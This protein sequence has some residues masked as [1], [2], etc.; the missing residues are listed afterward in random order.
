MKLVNILIALTL[1]AGFAAASD[2]DEP[3][4]R[5][6]HLG[7]GPLS[8]EVFEAAVAHVDLERCPAEFAD[9]EVF[10]RMTLANGQAHVFV[11]SMDPDTP[12]LAIKSLE[13]TE[14]LLAF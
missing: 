6:M 3:T 7:D 9:E 8:Y 1:P 13:L 14:D 2:L 12:L 5:T 11:F 10:C 4:G